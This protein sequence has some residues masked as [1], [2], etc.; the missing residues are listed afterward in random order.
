MFSTKLR[1]NAVLI[2][3]YDNLLQKTIKKSHHYLNG[4]KQMGGR[5]KIKNYSESEEFAVDKRFFE[6]CPKMK[7]VVWSPKFLINQGKQEKHH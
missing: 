3:V 7:S 1:L 6:E 5:A 4:R 2:G